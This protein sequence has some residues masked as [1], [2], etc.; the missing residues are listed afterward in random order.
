M[1]ARSITGNSKLIL[2]EDNFNQLNELDK[3]RFLDHLLSRKCTVIVVSN[4]PS[5]AEKFDRIIVLNK[6]EVIGKGSLSSFKR[7][8]WFKKVFKNN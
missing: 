8:S 2:L 7:K 6:G 3:T 4:D 5:V 1:L